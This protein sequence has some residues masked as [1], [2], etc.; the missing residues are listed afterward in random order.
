MGLKLVT[1]MMMIVFTFALAYLFKVEVP[2]LWATFYSQGPFMQ[3]L[4][5][6]SKFPL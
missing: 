4:T 5:E 3:T 1:M 2:N 6:L